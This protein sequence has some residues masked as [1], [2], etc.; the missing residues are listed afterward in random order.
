MLRQRIVFKPR[1]RR[2]YEK[3]NTWKEKK[4]EKKSLLS[5]FM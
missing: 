3:F 4:E 2:S 5:N 1:F